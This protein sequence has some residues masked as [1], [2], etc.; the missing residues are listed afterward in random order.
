MQKATLERPDE[1]NQGDEG[2]IEWRIVLSSSKIVSLASESVH[3][4]M[5]W[6]TAL[7]RVLAPVNKYQYRIVGELGRGSTCTVHLAQGPDATLFA[8]KICNRKR[9][10]SIREIQRVGR[11]MKVTTGLDK[12]EKEIAIMKKLQHPNVLRLHQVFHDQLQD[13]IILVLDYAEKG[14]LMKWC[15]KTKEYRVNGRLGMEEDVARGYFLQVVEGL[16]YLHQNRIC[17]RDLKPENL[18]LNATGLVIADFGVAHHTITGQIA[19]SEGT[20]AFMPPESIS[21][22]QYSIFL[23]DI[24]SLGVTLYAMIY[25]RLPFQASNIDDLFDQI[26]T[27]EPTFSSTTTSPILIELLRRM[28]DKNPATRFNLQQIRCHEWLTQGTETIVSSTIPVQVSAHEIQHAITPIL[29]WEG[30][31]R[32]QRMA[33]HWKSRASQLTQTA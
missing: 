24:W 4:A 14:Q 17:H 10:K 28:L 8:L 23:A 32:V 27:T 11:T 26:E 21:G 19:N 29:N 25:G 20:Y 2:R 3:E 33:K 7:E 12:V 6:M 16:T 31:L 9:L 22:D 13:T 1:S 18:L 5:K 15:S 30:A